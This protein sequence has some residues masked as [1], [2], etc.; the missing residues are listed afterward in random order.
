MADQSGSAEAIARQVIAQ[1]RREIASAWTH[2]EAARDA[3]RR[4]RW[5]LARWSEQIGM[6]K[7]DQRPQPE[8]SE[9]PAVLRIGKFVLVAPEAPIRGGGRRNRPGRGRSFQ[10]RRSRGPAVMNVPTQMRSARRQG[11]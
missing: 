4:S 6:A 1:C 11:R 3:L 5:M 2:V 7:S 9:R 10:N 8:E